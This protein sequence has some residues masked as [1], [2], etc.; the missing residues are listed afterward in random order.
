MPK[1]P[2]QTSFKAK[3]TDQLERAR[4][5]LTEQMAK[6]EGMKAALQG[7]ALAVS[8]GDYD[9][10]DDLAAIQTEEALL[11]LIQDGVAEAINAE[12]AR[13]DKAL[14]EAEQTRRRS[15]RK[16]ID[17]VRQYGSEFQAAAEAL[18]SC[19][20]D[21]AAAADEARHMLN[22][23]DV[24]EAYLQNALSPKIATVTGEPT[25]GLFVARALVKVAGGTEMPSPI[26]DAMIP[27]G[28]YGDHGVITAS[29]QTLPD[30]LDY[31]DVLFG[32]AWNDHPRAYEPQTDAERA[33]RDRKHYA[34]LPRVAVPGNFY[35]SPSASDFDEAKFLGRDNSHLAPGWAAIAREQLGRRTDEITAAE[36]P[37]VIEARRQAAFER[38]LA[39][40]DEARHAFHNGRP[41]ADAELPGQSGDA[42]NEELRKAREEGL[43]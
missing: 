5:R 31:L 3:E 17:K 2:N 42:I 18:R 23:N 39:A 6:I 22:Q 37:E 38:E 10:S 29:L 30:A 40:A 1:A 4:Q 19:W 34:S 9:P 11:L 25:L 14:A 41:A 35:P 36:D 27:I 15:I 32:S 28:E 21:L 24:G 20:N 43:I 7:H 16:K 13:K 8:L 12:Q 26:K 33:E